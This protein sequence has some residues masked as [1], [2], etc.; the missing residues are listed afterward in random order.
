MAFRYLFYFIGKALQNSRHF[1][2]I[3]LITVG[4]IS[5]SLV[6]VSVF[7][8]VFLNLR[9]YLDTWRGQIQ[10]SAY[11][12]DDALDPT[13]LSSLGDSLLN[14]PEVKNITI[15]SKDDALQFLKRSFPH[16]AIALESM[17]KN[18]LPAS[19]D[20]QLNESYDNLNT[21]KEL[22]ERIRNLSGVEEV[23]YG[24]AWLEGYAQMLDFF[25]MAAF[26]VGAVV[27][28]ATVFIISNT[29]RLTIYA[30]KEEIEVLRFVGAANSFIRVPFYVEG[31][32][33]GLAG[34]LIALALVYG[35]F[36]LFTN[37]ISQSSPF[38]VHLM[39]F[40]FLSSSYLL[41]VIVGGMLTGLLGSW[42]SLGRYLRM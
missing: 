28:L 27:I 18:P 24:A 6:V 34:S 8:I 7:L 3:N 40:S 14:F 25:V 41:L 2:L 9:T 17:Q 37:W 16:Q 29:I 1:L 23:E 22:A 31:I 33:Q 20:I 26:V 38:P 42:C 21:I 12:A 32:L 13:S 11:L 30:R 10:I 19:I 36:C 35:C 39:Q 5:L 4:I 15:I